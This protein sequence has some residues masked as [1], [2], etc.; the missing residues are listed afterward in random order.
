MRATTPPHPS[1]PHEHVWT[2]TRP[3]SYSRPLYED[4]SN[5]PLQ[6]S[7]AVTPSSGQVLKGTE[8]FRCVSEGRTQPSVHQHRFGRSGQPE[9]IPHALKGSPPRG[10]H[11]AL[12]R[13]C[14]WGHPLNP[15][16][17]WLAQVMASGIVASAVVLVLTFFVPLRVVTVSVT[18]TV[19][20]LGPASQALVR[21]PREHA[22]GG[23]LHPLGQ[24]DLLA[25]LRVV[26]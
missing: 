23:E 5:D 21:R 8:L 24:G 15:T 11:G 13:P 9:P 1:S 16:C 2:A 12:K 4:G 17:D 25:H 22:L 7:R 20:E 19:T 18:F 3:S 14:P 26:V 6:R 10:L